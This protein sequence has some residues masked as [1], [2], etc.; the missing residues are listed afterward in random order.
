MR[1]I[2]HAAVLLACCWTGGSP[3]AQP[4]SRAATSPDASPRARGG[5]ATPPNIDAVRDSIAGPLID[6]ISMR[7][8]GRAVELRLG[9]VDIRAIDGD[10][11]AISGTGDAQIIGLQGW[12]GFRFGLRYDGRLRRLSAPDVSI[13]RVAAGERDLPNDPLL[14]RQLE[15]LVTADLAQEYRKPSARLHLER[16]STVEGD[17]Q[18]LR[19]DAQ[20]TAYLDPYGPGMPLTVVALYDRSGGAWLKLEYRPGLDAASHAWDRQASAR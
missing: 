11:R 16:V 17:G 12:I 7:L 4:A 14:V 20:A 15:A 2:F 10:E 8:G 5:S 6:A 1:Q 9:A 18:R 19:I 13:D 3:A